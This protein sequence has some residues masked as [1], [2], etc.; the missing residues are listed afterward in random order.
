MPELLTVRVATPADAVALNRLVNSAYRGESSRAG[1]A[2]EADLLG[3]QRTDLE[4]VLEVIQRPDSV[5]LLHELRGA[6]I[7]CI[8][9]EHTARGCYL[10]MLTIDPTLQSGGLGRAMLDVAEDFAVREWRCSLM[11]MTVIVQRNSLIEWYERRG[12]Q[13]SGE[14]RPFPYGDERFGL[15]LRPDLEFE[16]LT[17]NLS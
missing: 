6:I 11:Y 9:L 4:A 10:G 3:G 1:W 14:R 15:P 2:T 5:L 7:A 13:R 12:Y 17:K 16:I 8:H